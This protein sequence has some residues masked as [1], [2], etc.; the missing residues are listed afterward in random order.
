MLVLSNTVPGLGLTAGIFFSVSLLK[1]LLPVTHW[2]INPTVPCKKKTRLMSFYVLDQA[3]VKWLTCSPS[4]KGICDI[5]LCILF[6]S[7]SDGKHIHT[8]YSVEKQTIESIASKSQLLFFE[9]LF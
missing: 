7:C 3:N 6:D 9:C 8:R 5:L 1:C 2:N 4:P